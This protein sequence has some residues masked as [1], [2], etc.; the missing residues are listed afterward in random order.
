MEVII[1]IGFV[2]CCIAFLVFCGVF[3]P[4]DNTSEH[5]AKIVEDMQEDE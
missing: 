5:I 1:G 4:E 3:F 2:V